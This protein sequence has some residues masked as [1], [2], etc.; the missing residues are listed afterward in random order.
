MTTGGPAAE[1]AREIDAAA[2]AIL[3]E[4]PRDMRLLRTGKLENQAG[5][6]GQYF[7]TYDIAAGML[8]DYAGYTLFPLVRMA[9]DPAMP[10][11]HLRRMV[12]EFDAPYSNYLGYSGLQALGGYAA[13]IRA[14]AKTATQPEIAQL[15]VAQNRFA[16]R[17]NA[18]CHHYF[19][20]NLGDQF[21]YQGGS[22]PDLYDP[23][24]DYAPPTA[25]DADVV[26]SWEPLGIEV[27]AQLARAAN[28]ELCDDLLACLPF[29]VLQDHAVVTGQSMYAWAPM[30]STAPVPVKE[31][32]NQAPLGRLR[33]SQ[34]TGQKLIVQ[35]GPTSEDLMAPV[36][37]QVIGEDL[38]LLDA[39]GAAVWD[40]TFSDK[41]LIWLTVSAY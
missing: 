26:L 1:L 33:F 6:Y 21:R 7:S 25:E 27:R 28:P 36:L 3:R 17:I 15:L 10:V 2:A 29:T 24:A 31:R 22:A 5:S 18:W 12:E 16:N 13:Q 9:R 23:P 11:E 40:S 34:G 38:H 8:R 20:W 41:S 32:I 39:V 30:M 35:Y 19:P 4:E 14:L 37:G